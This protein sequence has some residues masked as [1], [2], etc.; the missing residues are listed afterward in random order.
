MVEDYSSI[1]P[2]SQYFILLV[3]LVVV[4]WVAR[5]LTFHVVAKHQL[6]IARHNLLKTKITEHLNTA[7]QDLFNGS[8]TLNQLT[9]PRLYKWF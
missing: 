3:R 2:D 1:L 4:S 5:S 8:H 7:Q 9:L 6:F